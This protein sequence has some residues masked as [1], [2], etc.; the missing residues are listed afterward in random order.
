MEAL[1]NTPRSEEI[2][3]ESA[4]L[5]RMKGFHATSIRNIGECMGVT[6]AALY[7]HFKNK[8]E[9]LFGIM[10]QGIRY[11]IDAV[12]SA[13]LD[14]T[15]P[16]AKLKAAVDAHVRVS[17]LNQDFA[18]V[19]LQDLRHLSPESRTRIIE[20]RDSYEQIWADLLHH[21]MDEGCIKP[22]TELHLLRL[23]IFGTLNLIVTWYHPEGEHSPSEIAETYYDYIFNGVLENHR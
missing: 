19:L 7:Y 23:M 9:V 20:E 13:I 21:C 6:S 16:L 2:M 8:D 11:V 14:E 3:R 22:G 12:E 18:A 17:V 4:R 1:N 5:F 15:V 10:H